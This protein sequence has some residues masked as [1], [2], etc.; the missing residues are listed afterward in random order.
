MRNTFLFVT[1]L[2]LLLASCNRE[3]EKMCTDEFRFI[4]VNIKDSSG[5]AVRLDSNY[6]VLIPI[7]RIIQVKTDTIFFKNGT[8]VLITD[9]ERELI[10]EDEET[11]IRFVGFKNSDQ[12]VDK[13]FIV[14]QDGCHIQLLSGITDITLNRN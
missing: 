13:K 7:N 11:E 6:T 5:N 3:K 1:I 14:T 10:K 2:L 12:I 4:I 9:S 8:Y